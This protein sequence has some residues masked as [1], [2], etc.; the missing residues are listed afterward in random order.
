MTLTSPLG[1]VETEGME[2]MPGSA[3]YLKSTGIFLHTKRINFKR[4]HSN[5]QFNETLI[6]LTTTKR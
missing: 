4:Q 3:I 5:V 1:A 2:C 6:Y